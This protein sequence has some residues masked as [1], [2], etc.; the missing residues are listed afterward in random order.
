MQKLHLWMVK[1]WD[2]VDGDHRNTAEAAVGVDS[3]SLQESNELAEAAC[4]SFEND[5]KLQEDIAI[6]AAMA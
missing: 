2:A 3:S 5:Q 1:N 6:P 4:G